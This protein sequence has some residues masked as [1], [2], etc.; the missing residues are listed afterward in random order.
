[1]KQFI[2]LVTSIF[3]FLGCSS[4]LTQKEELYN[5]SASFWY[6]EIVKDIKM[7]TLDKAD[8]AYTSLSSE[9]VASPLLKESL[10]IL[11]KA[12]NKEEE[13]IMANYYIDEYI[14]RYAS[15]KNIS[16]LKYMKIKSNFQSFKRVNRDQKL[17]LDTINEANNYLKEY[18]NSPYLP[19]VQ[20]ILTRLQLTDQVLN[21]NIIDLYKKTGKKKS[22]KIYE[23]KLKSSWLKNVKA[24]DPKSGFFSKF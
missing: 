21:Q 22:A 19:E 20:T 18:S 5:K 6:K 23:D 10:L 24:R 4:K 3:L 15:S 13:Y 14:K 17:L 7:G 2:F 12:H 8:E 1:M 16:Y 11:A 9:H